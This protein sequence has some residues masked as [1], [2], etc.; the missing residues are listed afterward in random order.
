MRAV[1]VA[2]SGTTEHLGQHGR[3]FE[4]TEPQNPRM[5]AQN[6][7]GTSRPWVNPERAEIEPKTTAAS[8]AMNVLVATFVLVQWQ[9]LRARPHQAESLEIGCQQIAHQ[10]A[11]NRQ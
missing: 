9:S 5:E 6:T 7:N 3:E 2:Q 1:R 4:T 10:Q 11:A 8:R